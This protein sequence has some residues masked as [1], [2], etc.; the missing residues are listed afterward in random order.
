[1]QTE[2]RARVA[3]WLRWLLPLALAALLFVSLRAEFPQ[4]LATLRNAKAVALVSLP[5]FLIWNQIATL[6][7]RRLLDATEVDAVGVTSLARLRIEAQ[8]VNQ[9]V[10]AA[11]LAGEVFRATSAAAPSQIGRASVATALDN[12]AGTV[13]GLV[14][15]V[16]AVVL[17][18][19]ERSGPSELGPLALLGAFALV[20]VLLVAAV[21][22]VFAT[23]WLKLL[24]GKS[25]LRDTVEIFSKRGV[26]LRRAL[27]EA[28][29]LRLVERV[30]GVFE[31]YVLFRA[32]GVSL[33]GTEAALISA[34]I[35]LIS[36]AAFFVPGQLGVAEAAVSSAAV[37]LGYPAAIGLSAALLRRARQLVVC[38]V[39]IVS[40]LLR[41][42]GFRPLRQPSVYEE[43]G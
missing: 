34:V 38:V 8:A 4:V 24:S 3:V 32:T 21:P 6:A 23:R 40:L 7:W 9:V 28:V 25:V 20:V 31:I 12:V 1:M 18:L 42:Q 10:P 33:S 27:R 39:G 35:V 37:L 41:G 43:V 16:A 19:F 36:F 5:L 13:A 15:A 14:F 29:A 11:G 22:F 2:P 26:A 30:M 17:H